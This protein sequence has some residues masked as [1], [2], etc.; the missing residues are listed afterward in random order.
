VGS[1]SESKK[2]ARAVAEKNGLL[3]HEQ[4]LEWA[5]NGKMRSP[6]GKYWPLDASE[7][8]TCARACA[9][10]YA[11]P[12]AAVQPVDAPATVVRVVLDDKMLAALARDAPDKLEVFRDVLRAL[13]SGGGEPAAA[14][15]LLGAPL[16]RADPSRY[17]RTLTEDGDFAGSA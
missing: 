15:A 1:L 13:Q 4:L 12:K 14:A 16:A 5:L 8:I 10:Y 3:P 6:S 7:R 2:V 9:N 17:A 11:H